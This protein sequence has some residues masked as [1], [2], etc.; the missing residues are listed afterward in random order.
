MNT[1]DVQ[2]VLDALDEIVERKLHDQAQLERLQASIQKIIHLDSLQGEGGEAIKDHFATLHLPVLAAFQLFIGQYIEQLKQIRSNLLNFESSSAL[3]RE[4]FLADVK[5]GLDRV[6][7]YAIEDAT[8]IESIRASIADLLPLPPF[9]MEPV[10]R[11]AQQGKD[12]VRVTAER[13]GNLD[14][15]N[16][17]VLSSAKSTLQEL[18]TVVSQVADW[19]SGGVIPSPETQ[20]EIDA[21]MEKLYQ[22]VVTQALQMAPLDRSHVEGREGDLY[23]DVLPLEFLYTGA[24]APLYSGLK[25]AN[26]YYLN[27]FPVSA[28][29]SNE[30]ALQAC[31]APAMGATQAVSPSYFPLFARLSTLP[32]E[33]TVS[34]DVLTQQLQQLV[35]IQYQWYQAQLRNQA[36]H[37][38]TSQVVAIPEYMFTD[39]EVAAINTYLEN[40]PP[41]EERLNT[42]PIV[43]GVVD[44]LFGDYITLVDPEASLGE[45]ALATTFILVKPA[46]V[47]GVIY[48]LS[49]ARKVK[50][51]NRTSQ[52]N[53][54]NIPEN[55]IKHSNI[56]DF[57]TNPRTGAISR[58]KGGG[59]GQSNIEFLEKNNVDYNIT[60]VYENGVRVGNVPGHKVKAKRTGSNQSWFPENWTESDITAAGAKVAESPKFAN[61]ENGVAIFGEY[62][63]VRVGVIKTNGEIGTIFPDAT[64][65]P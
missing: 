39:Q 60:Q 7:R 59:H 23:Q 11:Y 21:N 37:T 15:A 47:G 30:Q 42:N 54:V 44:F 20:A 36:I 57:T 61:A 3:I 22:N 52:V 56:G 38:D 33:A 51:G 34:P 18:T 17:A 25:A 49:K 45:K 64:K 27:H 35:P 41:N 14:E 29:L 50:T 58:M 8:A 62:K 53:K 28:I 46:K 13:L 9:S 24:Y 10:L 2:E 48:D 6:E 31:R 12:H 63:G 65:Q 32:V 16:E 26:W 5:N 40:H 19:S 1:L 4:E 55:S 43:T